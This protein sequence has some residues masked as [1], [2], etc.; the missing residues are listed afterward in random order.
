M[1]ELTTEEKAL[2]NREA[3][4]K[5]MKNNANSYTEFVHYF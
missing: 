2:K 3:V 1:A 5:C 4:K